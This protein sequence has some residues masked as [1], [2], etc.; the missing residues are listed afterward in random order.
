MS[1]W[2]VQLTSAAVHGMDRS[3]PRVIPAVIEFLYGPL[4]EQ[5][6]QVGRPLRGDFAGLFG[7]HRGDYR[8]LYEIRD[9]ARI[10]VVH[11]IA[12]RADAYRTPAP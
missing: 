11:R 9:E 7:A 8:I 4:A 12:H 1:A 10:V 6:R 3:P 2:S 5:P